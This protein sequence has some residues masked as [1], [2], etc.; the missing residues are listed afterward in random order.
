[1]AA[2]LRGLEALHQLTADCRGRA[3][4]GPGVVDSR[5]AGK[6]LSAVAINHSTLS[7]RRTGTTWKIDLIL[8][9]ISC[10]LERRTYCPLILDAIE[11][12]QKTF[13]SLKCHTCKMYLKYQAVR[14]LDSDLLG[15]I[16]IVGA[17][18]LLY[19]LPDGAQLVRSE[20]GYKVGQRKA[21]WV[22]IS[23]Q[24]KFLTMKL[25]KKLNRYSRHNSR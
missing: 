11:N 19:W 14:Q 4:L 16:G 17:S 13:E 7:S 6:D 5:G 9:F 23:L 2:V 15:G 3:H 24:L 12:N 25:V 22:R 18:S 10:C 1:M 20:C 21:L 8:W